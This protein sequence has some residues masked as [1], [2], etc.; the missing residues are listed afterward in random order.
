[1]SN[2]NQSGEKRGDGGGKGGGNRRRY[3]RRRK[4]AAPKAQEPAAKPAPRKATEP[5]KGRMR[6]NA[7]NESAGKNER[8]RRGGRR[9][10]RRSRSDRPEETLSVRE[11]ALTAID[12]DYKPPKEVFVYTYVLRPGAPAGHEFRAEHFS[13]VGRRLE[14]FEIDLSPLFPAEGQAKPEPRPRLPMDLD[15]DEEAE[16]PDEI[17]DDEE[18]VEP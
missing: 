12:Q 3:F 5:P 11:S 15:D 13:R 4:A 10:R 6:T 17:D 9:R 18:G 14:D 16:F 7:K 1:M 2:G 8:D